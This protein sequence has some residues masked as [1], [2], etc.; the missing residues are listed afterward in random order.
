MTS[1]NAELYHRE[2]DRRTDCPE[3]D[4]DRTAIHDV[5]EGWLIC[6]DCDCVFRLSRAGSIQLLNPPR[7][8]SRKSPSADTGEPR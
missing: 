7:R 6:R 2:F 5:D 3:C 1:V 4:S 8:R